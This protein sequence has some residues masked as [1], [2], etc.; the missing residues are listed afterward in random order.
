MWSSPCTPILSNAW[1]KGFSVASLISYSL[2][3]TCKWVEITPNVH[4]HGESNQ[5]G[6]RQIIPVF[7]TEMGS[8]AA[9][10]R[11]EFACSSS[12]A[13]S[14][15]SPCSSHLC[16]WWTE[17]KLCTSGLCV[18]GCLSLFL[19]TKN[20]QQLLEGLLLNESLE[21]PI[22]RMF[23]YGSPSASQERLT[24]VLSS[25]QIQF[26]QEATRVSFIKALHITLYA[27]SYCRHFWAA[28]NLCDRNHSS[29]LHMTSSNC[30][31]LSPL[32]CTWAGLSQLCKLL[33][34]AFHPPAQESWCGSSERQWRISYIASLS[35]QSEHFKADCSRHKRKCGIW[36]WLG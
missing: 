13:V 15:H 31:V 25:L 11:C 19:L 26:W 30:W 34:V 8:V 24:N 35:S 36:R 6:S 17:F 9:V 1:E 21:S 10:G 27:H 12:P 5:M 28:I 20:L 22:F 33:P 29:F 14:C 4:V 3:Q 32:L 7:L 23:P 2:L 18:W 16:H